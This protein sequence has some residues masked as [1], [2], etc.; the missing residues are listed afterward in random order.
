MSVYQYS[1]GGGHPSPSVAILDLRVL[2][3]EEC[4]ASVL[5]QGLLSTLLFHHG[6][7]FFPCVFFSFCSM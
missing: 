4:V 6:S 5:F 7:L 1:E 2:Y 3:T